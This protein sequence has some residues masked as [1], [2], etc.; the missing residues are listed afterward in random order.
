MTAVVARVDVVEEFA[1][2]DADGATRIGRRADVLERV[3]SERLVVA[4]DQGR[5]GSLGHDADSTPGCAATPGC[6]ERELRPSSRATHSPDAAV[7]P[8]TSAIAP[9]NP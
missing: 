9:P 8:A 5:H 7:R 2:V 6:A 3:A 1:A 4:F